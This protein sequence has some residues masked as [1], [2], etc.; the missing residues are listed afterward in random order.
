MRAK[1]HG[2]VLAGLILA[3]ACPWPAL[4]GVAVKAVRLW[5]APD[6]SRITLEL[7]NSPQYKV[8]S[9]KN[10][11]RLVL[12]LTGVDNGP[13]LQAASG[14]VATQ[15]PLIANL[16]SGLNAPGVTR[17]VVELKAE[18]KANV[19]T[20]PP[21]G[22]YGHRLV[23]DL[24]PSAE[25]PVANAE[26][27]VER[28]IAQVSQPSA[29]EVEIES[30]A[31]AAHAPSLPPVASPAPAPK[32]VVADKP[33]RQEKAASGDKP[34]RSGYVRLITVALD[35]GHGG[36]D[37]GAT[38]ANGSHEKDVTLDV[39]RRLKAHIDKMENMRAVLTRDGDYFIPLFE[40]V[41][42]A[43]KAQ[44][45]LFVSIHADAFPNTAARGSS[46]FALSEKGATSVAARWLAK[47]E[48]AADLIGGVNI[49]VKDKYL[50]QTLIDLTQTATISDSLKLGR[51]VLSE[52]G[53]INDLHRGHVE[54]AGFAVLKAPDIPS[55]LV[56]T[57]F[58]SNP[59]EEKRLLSEAYQ[60]RLAAAIAGGIKR[61]F[62]KNPPL[63]GG[64]VARNL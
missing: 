4:A 30:R 9:L 58:I 34:R 61:Y 47:R 64:K 44:A 42:K 39:A 22:E 54:Q 25:S 23:I 48:N 26:G 53:D 17:V 52:L 14:Q 60:E 57:A 38:G 46:V 28:A 37:P 51:D 6:Y 20:L 50:K 24:Y 2:V 18:V 63:A 21:L 43:R 15:D 10:P 36:E 19:F 55:I 12:D 32:L 1:G 35:A 11:D 41:A 7:S 56:E 13:V 59:A 62:D 31:T 45:D 8:F 40:R 27:P 33:I 16:R 3:L 49:D 5:P 29:T